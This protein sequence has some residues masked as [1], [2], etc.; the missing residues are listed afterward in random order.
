[1]TLDNGSIVLV[2]A[3]FSAIGFTVSFGFPTI[4]ASVERL[5]PFKAIDMIP[6]SEP[7]LLSFSQRL[8]VTLAKSWSRYF[9]STSVV[10]FIAAILDLIYVLAS[11]IYSGVQL[12]PF[13]FASA[14]VA[15]LALI[16]ITIG[17]VCLL[18]G[19]HS[20]SDREV[21]ELVKEVQE[22]T[23]RSYVEAGPPPTPSELQKESP[24]RAV[25]KPEPS[26]PETSKLPPVTPASP[27]E[28]E[29]SPTH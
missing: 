22:A 6:G 28:G 1:M 18:V 27:P 2:I 10:F 11:F 8:I 21:R 19:A 7:V 4:V 26:P 20:Y 13:L 9:V 15:F 14:V 12:A 3:T 29:E 5:R 16:L 23:F 25:P 24:K 17:W